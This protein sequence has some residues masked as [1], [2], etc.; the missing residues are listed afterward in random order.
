MGDLTLIDNVRIEVGKE[1]W[2]QYKYGEG[3]PWNKVKITRTT[4]FGHPWME[5][6]KGV[7]YIDGIITDSYFVKEIT[8]DVILEEFARSWLI[9]KGYNGFANGS[10]VPKWFAEMYN[11]FNEINEGLIN[12]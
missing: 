12:D 11:D 8:N 3:N 10:S 1:Y 6:V 4:N 2:V 5:G 9:D 7:R